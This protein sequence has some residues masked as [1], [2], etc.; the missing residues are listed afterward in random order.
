MSMRD[1]QWCK[2]C[3][4]PSSRPRVVFVD[5]VCN[6]CIYLAGPYKQT[7]WDARKKEFERLIDRM[8][9]P[10]SP[11]DV[12]VPMSGGKDSATIAHRLKYEYGL[13]PLGVCYGQLIW[14]DVGYRN[15]QRVAEHID[16]AYWRVNQSVSRKLA[17][18]FFFNRGH[19]K[20][21]Y[22]S[23][24]CCVPLHEAIYR[25]I[26]LVCWAEFGEGFYG[27]HVLSPESYRTRNFA[28]VVENIVS[29]DAVNW[30]C[31]GLS[32]RDIFPY[33]H[34][35]MAD[36]QRVGVEGH[37]FSYYHPWSIYENARYARDKMGFE[38]AWAD[39]GYSID[40]GGDIWH[41]R[42]DG[43]LES[44]DSLDDAIDDADY[45]LMGIKFLF[46]RATRM[47]S[48]LIQSGHMT[49]E[50]GLQL[51]RQFD[52]E[53]PRRYMPEILDYLG[54]TKAEF[55]AVVDKHRNAEL[56]MKKDD[57][58]WTPRFFPQ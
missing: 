15:F 56:W 53:Y 10:G 44:Y 33:T 38:T 35:K 22:D 32:E 34:P 57:G 39:D 29:D 52:G 48:R 24:V 25:N 1:I 19:P 26:P 47:A 18:R 42:S 4:M 49:R 8:R 43:S 11:Y 5:G 12:I 9:R 2:K 46:G 27:G 51:V 41:G 20:K 50:R 6:A 7:D 13:N 30:S 45:F 16:I 54:V 40:I 36:I 17:R 28:E 14:T 3:L 55:D 37:Y 31:D 58:S 21:A 23:A